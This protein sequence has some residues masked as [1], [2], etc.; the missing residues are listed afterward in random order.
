MPQFLSYSAHYFILKNIHGLILLLW[1]L[2]VKPWILGLQHFPC[3]TR[4]GIKSENLPTLCQH[5]KPL[6]PNFPFDKI[7]PEND[8]SRVDSQAIFQ[9]FIIT[10]SCS[11]WSLSLVLSVGVYHCETWVHYFCNS[12]ATLSLLFRL[13]G[14]ITIASRGDLWSLHDKPVHSRRYWGHSKHKCPFFNM[15]V[16]TAM[17]GQQGWVC[18]WESLRTFVSTTL[19]KELKVFTI[20]TRLSPSSQAAVSD[21]RPDLANKNILPTSQSLGKFSSSTR[22]DH[23]SENIHHTAQQSKSPSPQKMF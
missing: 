1:I 20:R 7:K 6:D 15:A 11:I 19:E 17:W 4:E 2:A 14:A 3:P 9:S 22:L 18:F 16:F 21:W 12:S 5:I 8:S 10:C 13:L 23:R